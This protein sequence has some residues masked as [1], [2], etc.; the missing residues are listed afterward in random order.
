MGLVQL[1]HTVF[2]VAEQLL[3]TYWPMAQLAHLRHA[4]EAKMAA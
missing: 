4:V 1:A 2:A 3:T